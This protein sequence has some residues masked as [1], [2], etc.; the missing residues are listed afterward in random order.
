MSKARNYSAYSKYSGTKGEKDYGSGSVNGCSDGSAEP[1]R[2]DKLCKS[3]GCSSEEAGR[4][5]K[6]RQT[7]VPRCIQL[8]LGR[9]GDRGERFS[10]QLSGTHF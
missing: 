7:S 1:D 9:E 4:V 6:D 5:L 8:C 3:E 2:D 10:R